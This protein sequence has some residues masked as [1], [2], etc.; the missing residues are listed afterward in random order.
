LLLPCGD[1]VRAEELTGFLEIVADGTETDR[2]DAAGPDQE[3]DVDSLTRRLNFTWDRPLFPTLRLLV[4]GLFEESDVDSDS[5]L[6]SLPP[7]ENDST[8][9]R[10][11]PFVDL[12]LDTP[13][14]S[15]DLTFDMNEEEID[16]DA[17]PST[18]LVQKRFGSQ[19]GWRPVDLPSID[20][21]LSRTENYDRE[22]VFRDTIDDVFQLDTD[23][24]PIEA[25][26][27][28]YQA[29]FRDFD[30]RFN[31]VVQES[32]L[33]SARVIYGETFFKDRVSFNSDYTLSYRETETTASGFGDVLVPLFPIAGLSSID[34]TPGNDPLSPNPALI[35]Q[36]RAVGAGIDIGLPPPGGDTRPRNLGLDFG[37]DTE[38]DTLLVWIDRDL[39]QGIE[40]AF[41]WRVWVSDDNQFWTLHETVGGGIFGPFVNRF[42]LQ[43]TEVT[44]RYLKVVVDPLNTG[45]PFSQNFPNILI[46]ELEAGLRTPAADITTSTDATTHRYSLDS[47]VRI[48]ESPMLFY[49]LTY[50]L[51][52]TSQS[53]PIQTVTNGLS[54]N[55]RFSDVLSSF[56]R[57]S[58]EDGEERNEDRTAYNLTASLNATP[59]SA[60]THNLVF[61]AREVDLGDESND[62]TSVFLFTVAE[63]YRGIDVTMTLGR[64]ILESRFGRVR[65]TQ[66]N[67]GSTL[68]PHRTTTVNLLYQE[69]TDDFE[70]GSRAGAED[71]VRSE[72]VSLAFR[73]VSSL[74]LFGS[75]RRERKP[76]IPER[77]IDNYVFSWSPFPDGTLHFSF[78]YNETYRSEL[79][80]TERIV[81]PSVRWDV[82]P[83]SYLDLAYQK[84]TRDTVDQD[85]DTEILSG[86]LRIGF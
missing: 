51:S 58:R 69:K 6:G 71:V 53:A 77:T 68:V 30:D 38:V 61:S 10:I 74:Y 59:V 70:T 67:L 41:T 14:F 29:T 73:P 12:F 13:V 36:N 48:L 82:T 23:Y 85:V 35:D 62:D 55:H 3:Q 1:A 81:T 84:L 2:E 54:V 80:S 56:A 79:D 18:T 50:F 4:G 63:L 49:E 34:D 52:D 44:A 32:W 65:A 15:A 33:H 19:F 27:L 60:L 45:V 47:R 78:S 66:Y 17:A 37:S 7:I 75:H 42:E 25:L 39:D 57:L 72:Q 16:P 20:L 43:F 8:T 21:R 11:A 5:V 64:S 40:N 26:R 31:S 24:T 83:R 22:G 9:T 86:T 46:T 76:D 28:E